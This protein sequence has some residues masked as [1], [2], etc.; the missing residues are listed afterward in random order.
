MRLKACGLNVIYLFEASIAHISLPQE[1]LYQ[2]Q[3]NT[4][5]QDKFCVHNTANVKETVSYLASMTRMLQSKIKVAFYFL[6]NELML[7]TQNISY[8][9]NA[10]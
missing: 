4:E 7:K 10:L 5:I 3:T 6:P 9:I 8:R 1:T 2:A